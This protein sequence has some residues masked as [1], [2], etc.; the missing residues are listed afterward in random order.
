MHCHS[1]CNGAIYVGLPADR[2]TRAARNCQ[3]R[4]IDDHAYLR[5]LVTIHGHGLLA[6]Q[7]L[8]Y[9]ASCYTVLLTHDD[10]F[11]FL[12]TSGFG[13]LSREVSLWL[14]LTNAVIMTSFLGTDPKLRRTPK[15]FYFQHHYLLNCR[16][17][18]SCQISFTVITSVGATFLPTIHGEVFL[19]C[20]RIEEYA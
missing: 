3:P 18:Y 16:T 5:R 15:F 10:V 13:T 14:S 7:C 12:V 1:S 8:P 19:R 2:E 4:H 17:R 9:V 11:P 6:L 20:A